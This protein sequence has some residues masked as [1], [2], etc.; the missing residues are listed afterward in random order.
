MTRKCGLPFKNGW[1]RLRCHNQTETRPR[2]RAA[3]VAPDDTTFA[4]LHGR[5][6]APK[7][8]DWDQAVAHWRSLPSD[9]DA[10]FD[11]EVGLDAAGIVPMVTWGT[12][13][14]AAAPITE[15]VPD[16]ASE[17]DAARRGRL[18]RAPAYMELRPGMPL[19]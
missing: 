9:D 8:A 14:E 16:P 7:G 11:R 12:S 10:Q 1:R 19:A 4:Y 5:P 13:P 6:Y 17:P 15:R 2:A 3:M 18:E